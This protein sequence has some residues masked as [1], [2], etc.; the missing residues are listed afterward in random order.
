MQCRFLMGMRLMLV[1]L[2][3]LIALV[4]AF[5]LALFAWLGEPVNEPT[6]QDGHYK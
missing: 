2:V 3:E 1:F 6:G 5:V 4:A